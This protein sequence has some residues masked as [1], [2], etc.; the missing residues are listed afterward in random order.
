M[1][2]PFDEVYP[3]SPFLPTAIPEVGFSLCSILMYRHFSF[4]GLYGSKLL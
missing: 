1:Q 3:L 2:D 4:F